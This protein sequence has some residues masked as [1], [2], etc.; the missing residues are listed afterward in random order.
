MLVITPVIL[1][2]R[3]TEW[4]G[5]KINKFIISDLLIND[6]AT[7]CALQAITSTTQNVASKVQNVWKWAGLI[8][9]A[10][11]IHVNI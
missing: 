4:L 7:V 3:W 10:S 1:I 6:L 11:Q 2:K 5:W 8:I 9:F